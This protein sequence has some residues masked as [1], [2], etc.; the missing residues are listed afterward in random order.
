MCNSSVPFGL[1]ST[2]DSVQTTVT[3]DCGDGTTSTRDVWA[4]QASDEQIA[5]VV[6]SAARLTGGSAEYTPEQALLA[7]KN[8]AASGSIF[9]L[10]TTVDG[11]QVKEG[12]VTKTGGGA[13]SFTAFR[14]DV[15]QALAVG[16]LGKGVGNLGMNAA[17]VLGHESV[18]LWSSAALERDVLRIPWG[19]K[20]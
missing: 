12:A 8:L 15:L 1:C 11:F 19:F 14:Q 5:G 7:Y 20:P 18:H 6:S 9:V 16:D 10:P 2:G 3:V 17:T 13:R 4:Q